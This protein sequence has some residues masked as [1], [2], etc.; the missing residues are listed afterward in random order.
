MSHELCIIL[1]YV[2][3]IFSK[4]EKF[5]DLPVVIYIPDAS[6]SQECSRLKPGAWQ[7]RGKVVRVKIP[8]VSYF[9]LY[10]PFVLSHCLMNSWLPVWKDLP[11]AWNRH[12]GKLNAHGP[13]AQRSFRTPGHQ[14]LLSARADWRLLGSHTLTPLQHHYFHCSK[15]QSFE[16]SFK[17]SNKWKKPCI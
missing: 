16:E 5:R 7:E 10:P 12:A 17:T 6:D 13:R 4:V 2:I 14:G 1:Y 3:C 8:K 15:L 9:R 11:D